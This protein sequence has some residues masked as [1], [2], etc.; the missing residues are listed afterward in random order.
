M[1]SYWQDLGWVVSCHSSHI[2][3]SFGPRFMPKF[4]FP[5]ISW[6]QNDRISP[7]LYTTSYWQDHVGLLH[8]FFAHLYQS[9]GPW[10][11]P[12]FRFS[13]ISWE[14]IDRISPNYIYAFILTRSSHS[15]AMKRGGGP[16][17]ELRGAILDLGCLSFRPSIRHKLV[18]AQYLENS[19]I[20][21]NKILYVHWYWHDLD[22]DCYTTFFWYLY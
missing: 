12:D 2:C 4:H 22:C 15:P 16:F 18:S 3:T 17:F 9:Y 19:F 21:F 11:K 14:Q 7:N 6:E 1:H 10:F 5:S 13:P 20:E 8:I